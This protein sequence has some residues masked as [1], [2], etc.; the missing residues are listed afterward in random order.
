M[1]DSHLR[2]LLLLLRVVLQAC[3]YDPLTMAGKVH[4]GCGAGCMAYKATAKDCE[5]HELRHYYRISTTTLNEFIV[6]HNSVPQLC[7]P[8]LFVTVMSHCWCRF[9]AELYI[10]S[11]LQ[12]L[13]PGN[14]HHQMC[15]CAAPASLFCRRSSKCK[16]EG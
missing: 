14:M 9:N 15:T 12:L 5:Q 11:H 10:G 8:Q 7:M 1:C 16:P 6:W 2:L 4:P 13:Q 3:S